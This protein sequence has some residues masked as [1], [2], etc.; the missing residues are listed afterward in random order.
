MRDNTQEIVDALNEMV[1]DAGGRI[2]L[3][4]DAFTRADHFRKM[5]PRLDHWLG[6]RR[7]WDPDQ[8]LKSCQSVRMFG[9]EP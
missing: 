8:R 6:I 9:D 4:K 7:Q 3:A 5:E 2:Y 1:V